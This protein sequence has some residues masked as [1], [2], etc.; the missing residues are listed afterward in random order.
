MKHKIYKYND[1]HFQLLLNRQV[2]ALVLDH[3]IY[4]QVLNGYSIN[5]LLI[6]VY[7]QLLSELP[8]ADEDQFPNVPKT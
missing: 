2:C 1:P 7:P 4:N 5:P 6:G 3:M 8:R